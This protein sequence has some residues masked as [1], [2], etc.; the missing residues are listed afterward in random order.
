MYLTHTYNKPLYQISTVNHY[1]AENWQIESVIHSTRNHNCCTYKPQ[2]VC[3]FKMC[4]L[5]S[6]LLGVY[7]KHST[8]NPERSNH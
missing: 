2:L 8:P 3:T 4:M 6:V 5:G 7:S 1:Q